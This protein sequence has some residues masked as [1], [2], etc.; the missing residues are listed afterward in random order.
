M[1]LHYSILHIYTNLT[2][3]SEVNILNGFRVMVRTQ[4]DNEHKQMAVTLLLEEVGAW[5][6]H[7]ALLPVD[8]N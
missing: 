7:T 8:V 4:L 2:L 5:F 1:F 6:L 3:N